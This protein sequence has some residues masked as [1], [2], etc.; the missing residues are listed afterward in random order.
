MA[1]IVLRSLINDFEPPLVLKGWFSIGGLF[2][3]YVTACRNSRGH[4]GRRMMSDHEKRYE[5]SP[6]P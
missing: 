5:E 2:H 4:Q 6:A 3:N 1:G